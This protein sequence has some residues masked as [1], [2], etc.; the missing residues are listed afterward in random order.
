MFDWGSKV[1]NLFDKNKLPKIDLLKAFEY[2]IFVNFL[3]NIIKFKIDK[4]A[5]FVYN[6]YNYIK[7][8]KKVI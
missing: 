7:K 1:I 6:T 4:M 3:T 2:I 8:L 5:L